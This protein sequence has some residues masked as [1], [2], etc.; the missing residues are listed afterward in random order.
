[1]LRGASRI[2]ARGRRTALRA[3]KAL[4]GGEDQPINAAG[5]TLELI[6]ELA[7]AGTTLIADDGNRVCARRHR[8]GDLIAD[9]RGVRTKDRCGER[10]PT[11]PT[12][13][14]GVSREHAALNDMVSDM[15]GP[16]RTGTAARWA[17]TARSTSMASPATH[18]SMTTAVKKPES[19]FSGR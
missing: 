12:A 15:H 11:A 19:S 7:G 2:I 4:L 8:F 3:G 9:L 17:A 6:K 1:M 16:A 18:A 10:C 14:K 5:T 13:T